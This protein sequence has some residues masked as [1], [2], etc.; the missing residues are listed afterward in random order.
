MNGDG[1]LAP[2]A[3]MPEL[4]TG[5]FE[6][7][8]RKKLLTPRE[9]VDLGRRARVG[10]ER[11]RQELIE[12]NLRLVV[13]VA[14]KYR[15]H[16][17][18][19]EDLIQ[20]GNIGLMRAV[21]K[22]DPDRGYRFSTYAT[23]WIWQAV[24]RAIMDQGRTIRVPI[25]VAEKIRKLGRVYNELSVQR[26]RE[27][28][29]QEIAERLGWGVDEVRLTVDVVPDAVSLNSPVG[30]EGMALLGDFVEDEEASDVPGTVVQ[31]TESARL[32]EAIERLPEP[33]RRILLR[34]Y[35]LDGRE[36]A[37]LL[38]VGEELGMSRERVR[39]IQLLAERA[40]KTGGY[41]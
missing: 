34:R 7:V 3:G 18:P 9:E 39:Q 25:H 35:G 28:T 31:E 13:S 41:G 38:E 33:D 16:G 21:E 5:Y 4:L 1:F 24:Q 23:W 12:K 37:T 2:E 32:W 29:E 17:L 20:E 15:G 8:G 26:G 30:D 40:L 14:K 19:F 6:R 10:D 22:F 27:P 11:A 36:P